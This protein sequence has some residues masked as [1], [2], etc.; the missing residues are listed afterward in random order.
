MKMHPLQE[1]YCVTA[2]LIV[3]VW[4]RHMR[5]GRAFSQENAKG[6]GTTWMSIGSS[7]ADGK[8]RHNL[9]GGWCMEHGRKTIEKGNGGWVREK[10]GRAGCD[11][12][13]GKPPVSS[14]LTNR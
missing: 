9:T 3:M 1:I 6:G 10:V 12:R 11:K 7:D 4:L 2:S 13:S 8:I 5:E 14:G